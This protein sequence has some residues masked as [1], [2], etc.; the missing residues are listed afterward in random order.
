M[1]PSPL[2]SS[3]E[4]IANALY[5]VLIN[6]CTPLMLRRWLMAQIRELG[7]AL[8]FER[9][10]EVEAAE[11]KAIIIAAAYLTEEQFNAA[12][13]LLSGQL[14]HTGDGVE[15][16]AP[17]SVPLSVQPAIPHIGQAHPRRTRYR[18]RNRSHDQ[19]G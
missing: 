1:L 14:P 5:G 12:H 9:R 16:P 17:L 8:P 10:R 15:L 18:S 6:P 13:L 19:D 7:K 4:V 3:A 11:A 2:H